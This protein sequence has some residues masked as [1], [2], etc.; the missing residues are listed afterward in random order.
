VPL[1]RTYHHESFD[2]AALV[3]AKAGRTVSVVIPARDEAGTIGEIVAG[4]VRRLVEEVPLVDEVVVVDDRSGDG[5]GARAAAAGAVVVDSSAGTDHLGPAR[6]K[7]GALWKGVAASSGDLL[8]FVDGDVEDFDPRF[9]V[10]LLGPLLGP[11]GDGI[12]L[13]KG[14][15]ERP[16]DGQPRGG[17]RVTELAARPVLAILL[18]H[19]S[20]IV[21]P[22]AGELAAPRRVLERLP[23]VE[24]YGFDLA[25]LAD[26]AA[27]FGVGSL[28]QVDLGRRAHRN[29]PLHEL[30]PMATEVLM[31]ALSRAGVDVPSSVQLDAPGSPAVVV[32]AERPP[33]LEVPAY[34]ARHERAGGLR[35]G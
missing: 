10:G 9:V 34:R 27:T 28:A 8:A 30:G 22:L 11:D 29:R 31:A 1:I 26:A 32:H 15:Y 6:G 16:I 25:L 23:F 17:G 13:V 24:G 14:F 4:V 5:T 2:A 19:L 7:G 21:Q 33:L 18:D 35:G 12:S 20:G 3:A